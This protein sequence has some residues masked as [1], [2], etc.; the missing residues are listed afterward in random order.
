MCGAE[1][2]TDH[3]LIISKLNLQLKPS[4][5]P[6]GQGYVKRLNTKRLQQ[7]SIKLAFIETLEDRLESLSFECTDADADW[8]ALK[9]VLYST[10]LES[11]GVPARTHQ[12]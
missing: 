1:C 4:R 8:T 11:L 6:Q 9:T 3:R 7:E 12:D 5:R 2:W 10:S